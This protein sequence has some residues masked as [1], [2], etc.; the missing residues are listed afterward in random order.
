MAGII[1]TK[2]PPE[3]GAVFTSLLTTQRRRWTM[4]AL[5]LLNSGANHRK[6]RVLSRR[7]LTAFSVLT[8]IYM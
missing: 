4:T 3:G 6:M 5:G 2:T 7:D 8:S 1:Q